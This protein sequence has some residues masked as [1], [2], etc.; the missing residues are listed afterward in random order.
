MTRVEIDIRRKSYPAR[1]RAGEH[2][3]IRDLRLALGEGAFTCLIGPSG[4]GK[5]T[6]LNILAG[7]ERDFDGAVTFHHRH[8]GEAVTG[9]V[10]QNPRLLP[11]RTVRENIELALPEGISAAM[12]DALLGELGLSQA[13]QV[14][15]E[16]LSLGMSRRVAIARA[17]AV[18]PDLLLMDEPFVSLDPP[19]AKN[20]RQLLLGLW[21]ERPHTVLF[22]T[23][24][25]DEALFLGDRLVFLGPPPASIIADVAVGT[26]RA[27]RGK[28]GVLEQLRTRIV[29]EHPRLA[30]LFGA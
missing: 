30:H 2:V 21:A 7:L 8:A 20:A 6:L 13:Q 19:A 14:Y 11:W 23:H 10:F 24:D 18:E 28:A 26:V 9:Y 22:V 27:E 25:L 5:T 1:G 3:A 17:F 12:V 29:T 4:C 15:P 16:R